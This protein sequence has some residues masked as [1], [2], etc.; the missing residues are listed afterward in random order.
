MYPLSII[1]KLNTDP[2]YSILFTLSPYASSGGPIPIAKLLEI[3]NPSPHPYLFK[4]F[5]YFESTLPN[6]IN[7]LLYYSFGIPIPVSSTD[8][9][10]IVGL[11]DFN[12]AYIFIYPYF[13]NFIEF[14]I[15]IINFF[16]I[17]F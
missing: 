6:I 13:V 14:P 17:Q 12:F 5:D 11:L 3:V 9:S 15:I 16:K 2:S 7:I 10:T 8:N 1:R 4:F